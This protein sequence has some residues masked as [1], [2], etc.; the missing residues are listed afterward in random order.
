MYRWTTLPCYKTE[1]GSKRVSQWCLKS[2]SLATNE[3]YAL[4]RLRRVTRRFTLTSDNKSRAFLLPHCDRLDIWMNL[5]EYKRTLSTHRTPLLALL[6]SYPRYDA[7]L[8]AN[9]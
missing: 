7:V 6:L 1:S 8:A 3:E 5:N 9:C 4:A 2:S